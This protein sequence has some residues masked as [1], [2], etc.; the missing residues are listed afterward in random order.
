MADS[1]VRAARRAVANR[2]FDRMTWQ[3]QRS[4][5]QMVLG[6]KSP[7]GDRHGVYIAWI[8]GQ[9]KRRRKKWG[10]RIAGRLNLVMKGKVRADPTKHDADDREPS[11]APMQEELL[12][13]VGRLSSY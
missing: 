8:D 5:V 3:E 4:L 10:Y 1:I 7:G 9:E 11:G 13:E 6:G 2:Y 12:A